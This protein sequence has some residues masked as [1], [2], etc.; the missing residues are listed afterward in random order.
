MVRVCC[1]PLTWDEEAE[2]IFCKQLGSLTVAVPCSCGGLELTRE[3]SWTYLAEVC[4]KYSMGERKQSRKFLECVED[5][6]LIQLMRE[7]ARGSA[8]LNLSADLANQGGPS[9][10]EMNKCDVHLQKGSEGESGE[11]KAYWP[12]LGAR[13]DHGTGH[14]E[15]C[16]AACAR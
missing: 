4:W 3:V 8:W 16:P 14:L 1:R 11:L 2:E 15:C 9:G 13:E 5:Y 12:D 7:P 6:F 10:L